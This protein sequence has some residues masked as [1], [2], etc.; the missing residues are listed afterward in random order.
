MTVSIGYAV[1]T[2]VLIVLLSGGGGSPLGFLLALTLGPGLI[3]AVTSLAG[4][5]VRR[6]PSIRRWWISHGEIA[7]VGIVL[8]LGL[9]AYGYA[10]GHDATHYGSGNFRPDHS[11][12]TCVG[13]LP[14]RLV[15]ALI[16]RNAHVDPSALEKQTL[17]P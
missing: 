11:V 6:I 5:P 9:T 8:S 3:I 16:L 7:M 12:R 14:A 2:P 13:L 10:T 15:H 1:L 17:T 4:L